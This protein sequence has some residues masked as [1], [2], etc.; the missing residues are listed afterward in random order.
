MS[1]LAAMYATVNNWIAN[2]GNYNGGTRSDKP[3]LFCYHNWLERKS[4]SDPALDS[5]GEEFP[6]VLTGTPILMNEIESYVET[7][8]E[9]S[10]LLPGRSQAYPVRS[11][12]AF[13]TAN[14]CMRR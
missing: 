8:Q 2:G 12:D 9:E 13:N 10:G 7:Q 11:S 14:P 5:A 6:N 3:Y 4:M 1:P